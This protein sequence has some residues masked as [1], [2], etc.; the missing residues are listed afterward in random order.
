MAAE[1]LRVSVEIGAN[2]ASAL[3]YQNT[4]KVFG[5]ASACCYINSI[6]LGMGFNAQGQ[7]EEQL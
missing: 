5:S 7:R 4:T 1:Q 3:H 6:E 2:V